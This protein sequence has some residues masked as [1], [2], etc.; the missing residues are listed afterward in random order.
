[1][2]FQLKRKNKLLG[3]LRSYTIDQPFI[4]CKFEPTG[5]FQQFKPLFDEEVE[6]MESESFDIEEWDAAYRK[7]LDLNL[8]LIDLTDKSLI[9]EF[10]LHI[11][12]DKAWFRY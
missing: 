1:M 8:Q 4:Y 6:F 3:T 7:I 2:E 12:D 11:K 10:M 9:T 5:A